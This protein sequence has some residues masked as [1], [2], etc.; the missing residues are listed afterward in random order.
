MDEV[1]GILT[2]YHAARRFIRPTLVSGAVPGHWETL[3]AETGIC[4]HALIF[5]LFRWMLF[6]VNMSFC[7][8][9]RDILFVGSVTSG[10]IMAN[11]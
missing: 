5:S 10:A 2:T 4:D 1:R 9:R 7:K 11:S 3:G 6:V 8:S